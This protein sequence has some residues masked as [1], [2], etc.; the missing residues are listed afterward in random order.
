MRK[1]IIPS[2]FLLS[3]LVSG[4]AVKPYVHTSPIMKYDFTGVDITTLKNSKVCTTGKSKDVSVR[5]AAALAGIKTVY[6]VDNNTVYKTHLFGAPT[7]ASQCV[8][9]YG[10]T[11]NNKSVSPT[12]TND[13]NGSETA[14]TVNANVENNNTEVVQ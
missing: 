12:L 2:A 13:A 8:I 7:V 5:R 11:D 10:V 4:C 1:L 14:T 3:F 9:V 6:A